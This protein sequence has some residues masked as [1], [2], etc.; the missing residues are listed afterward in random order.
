MADGKV[1]IEIDA[2]SEKLEKVLNVMK[3]EAANTAKSI[4]DAYHR[5]AKKYPNS[6]RP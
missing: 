2:D 1:I 6:A 5:P 3:S 4:G